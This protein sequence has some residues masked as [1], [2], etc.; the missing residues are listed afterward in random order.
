M[1]TVSTDALVTTEWLAE[2]I[3]HPGLRIVDASY[4][5]PGGVPPARQQFLQG[6]IPGAQFFDVNAIADVSNPKEHAFPSA[7]VFAAKMGELGINNGHRVIAYDHLGGACAAARVW[8]MCRAFGHME[9]SVLSGGRAAWLRENRPLASGEAQRRPTQSFTAAD[10]VTVRKRE[11]IRNN[12]AQKAFQVV[13]ARAAGRF[14]GTTAE[15]RPGLQ[16]G[17]IPG[18]RNLPFLDLF[19]EA[20]MTFKTPAE[21]EAVF[22]AAGIDLNSP[23]VTTCGSGITACA[24]ALGAYLV[25]KTDVQLY[26]GSWLEWGSDPQSPVETGA[27]RP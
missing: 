3:E 19:D 16:S 15:P 23:M 10:A 11:E 2:H 17:H 18:S 9:V 27:L 25:G 12:I 5:V 20:T 22:A 14:A 21:L 6:H 26:D 13:D 24:V 4:F 1:S 7:A 8:F